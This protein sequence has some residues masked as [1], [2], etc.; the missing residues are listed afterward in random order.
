MSERKYK[1]LA[2]GWS[3]PM[4][5]PAAVEVI[6]EQEVSTAI[7]DT[8]LQIARELYD[9][10]IYREETAYE[11]DPMDNNRRFLFET[12]HEFRSYA[13]R[14]ALEALGWEGV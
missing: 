5:R 11:F 12:A 3:M 14:L 9:E 4:V 10:A 2:L 7:R 1:E 8:K 13:N 6:L